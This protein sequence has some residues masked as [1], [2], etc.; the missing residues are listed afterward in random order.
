M[1]CIP[2]SVAFGWFYFLV[3]TLP[4]AFGSIYGFPIGTIGLCYLSAGVGNI[5][6]SAVAGVINDKLYARAIAKNNG[7]AKTEL[8]LRSIYIAMPFLTAGP[9]MYGWLL[10]SHVHWM[11][12]LA[13]CSISKFFFFVK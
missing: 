2:T 7:V 11:G 9:L 5:S 12:P 6:G 8:R 1:I 13:S 3:T 4:S 10:Q